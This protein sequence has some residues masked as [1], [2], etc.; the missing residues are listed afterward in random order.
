MGQKMFEVHRVFYHDEA[1]TRPFLVENHPATIIGRDAKS[2][3]EEI[4]AIIDGMERPNVI[5]PEWDDGR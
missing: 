5:I 4:D 2:M 3:L 1:R